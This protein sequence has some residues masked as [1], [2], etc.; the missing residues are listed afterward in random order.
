[1]PRETGSSMVFHCF[2]SLDMVMKLPQQALHTAL[3]LE[4]VRYTAVGCG[5]IGI[6]VVTP[7]RGGKQTFT[8]RPFITA[9]RI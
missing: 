2:P 9:S 5:M 3:V 4:R 7:D 1:M 8:P 6:L